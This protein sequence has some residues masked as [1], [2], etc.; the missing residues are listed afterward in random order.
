MVY[1]L[2]KLVCLV[3]FVAVAPMETRGAMD[4][5]SRYTAD[6]RAVYFSGKP[7]FAL[8]EKEIDGQ[9]VGPI[10]FGSRVVFVEATRNLALAFQ[11][12]NLVD[13]KTISKS[14]SW[15]DFPQ[16]NSTE[17]I[18]RISQGLLVY[19]SHG[20]ARV[21]DQSFAVKRMRSLD[22]VPS[23]DGVAHLDAWGTVLTGKQVIKCSLN[24]VDDRFVILDL[25]Q[26][27]VLSRG[28]SKQPEDHKG[29]DSG[30][31]K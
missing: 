12:G 18:I 20:E 1:R 25:D 16:Y 23:M 11:N 4:D 28:V 13:K 30:E 15:K 17:A 3:A 31:K 26:L 14:R 22:I 21:L 5:H 9:F 24:E 10:Q 27:K 6:K 2:T 29:K 8:P 7:V 19:N